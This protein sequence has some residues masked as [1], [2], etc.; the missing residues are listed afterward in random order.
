MTGKGEK[1][2]ERERDRGRERWRDR[3]RGVRK[4][5]GSHNLFKGMPPMTYTS[6]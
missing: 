2:G 4:R 1:W 6:H 3:E 5:P